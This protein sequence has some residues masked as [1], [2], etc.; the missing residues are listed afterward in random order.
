RPNN[1]N[2]PRPANQI[3]SFLAKFEPAMAK[4]IQAC[5]AILRKRFPTAV[6][7]VYDNYNFLVFG[8][9]A[10]DRPSSTLVAI[11]ANSK[12]VGLSFYWGATLPDPHKIL[13]GSGS[14]N[15]FVRLPTPET[16]NDPRIAALINDAE[17]QAKIPLSKSAKGYTLIKSISA[18][19]RPR[20]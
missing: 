19:Q 14:Q 10:T 16:L 6:E 15:R 9:A 2:P 17:A 11:A 8:F 3:A 13:L 12:G 18:K 7:I 1:A 5:R 4:K 20:R